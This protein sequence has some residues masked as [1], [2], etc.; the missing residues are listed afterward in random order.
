[1]HIAAGRPGFT[2]VQVRHSEHLYYQMVRWCS[3]NQCQEDILLALL[4]PL[5]LPASDG[6]APAFSSDVVGIA[7]S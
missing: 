6:V 5:M 3:I 2:F 1:M 4:T 7:T